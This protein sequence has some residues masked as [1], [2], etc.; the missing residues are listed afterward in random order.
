MGPRSRVQAR[1]G[2]LTEDVPKK[3]AAR[4]QRVCEME[5]DIKSKRRCRALMTK[6][7]GIGPLEPR[8]VVG[9]RMECNGA[10]AL[11]TQS[12]GIEARW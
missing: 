2:L 6:N 12:R 10:V 1:D 7:R 3:P 11:T 8:Q 9:R 5:E 4:S